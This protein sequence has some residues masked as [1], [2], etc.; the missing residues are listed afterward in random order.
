[1]P[2][3]TAQDLSAVAKVGSRSWEALK[4]SFPNTPANKSIAKAAAKY[5]ALVGTTSDA[6]GATALQPDADEA[7]QSLQSACAG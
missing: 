7:R 1:M 5:L 2:H 4:P 6:T 3:E